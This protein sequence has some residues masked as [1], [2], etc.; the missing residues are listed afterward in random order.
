[1]GHRKKIINIDINTS[2]KRHNLSIKEDVS[3]LVY[4]FHK[5][6]LIM[7]LKRIDSNIQTMLLVLLN[8]KPMYYGIR[9]NDIIYINPIVNN[10]HL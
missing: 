9:D 8:I 4:I 1:M 10:H 6:S 5:R 2:L 3:K 7:I